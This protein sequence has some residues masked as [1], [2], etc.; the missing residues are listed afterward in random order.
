MLTNSNSV[1]SN[2]N[3]KWFATVWAIIIIAPLVYFPG[4]SV[5]TG[6]PW[7]V[8]LIISFVLFTTL[9]FCFFTQQKN[10][11]IALISPK[12]T[13]YIIIP[14]CALIIWSAISAFWADSILS[15]AHHSLVWVYYLIFFLLSI[16]IVSDKRL[17]KLST[18][19]LGSV[20]TIICLCCVI[21]FIQF[22]SQESIGETFGTRFGR[23]A[24]IFA[25]LLPLF[26]SFILRLNRKH[27]L[28]AVCVTSFLWLGL[29][30]AGSRG[31]LFSSIIG[32]S[33][34][35][36]LRIF[37]KKTSIEKR[38]LVLALMG[39]VFTV[40]FV[41]VSLL[42]IQNEKKGSTISRF[43]I[44]DEKE[45][46]NSF[47]QNIRFLYAGVGKEMFFENYLIGVGADNFGLEFNK[48]RAVFSENVTNK[49]TAQQNEDFQAERAH[50]E[51]LQILAELGII[52]G[53]IFLCLLFGIAKLGFAEIV[54]SRFERSNILTHAAIGG[55]VAFLLSSCFSSFSFRL[56]QNGLVFF[57]L[58]AILLRNFVVEK[59]Q[60]KQNLTFN[61]QLKLIFVSIAL[62]AS[63]SLTVFSALKAT[64]Q[65][66]TYLA[67]RQQNFETAKTYYENA[68]MLDPAN[69]AAESSFGARLLGENNYQESAAHFQKSVEKGLNDSISYSY[70]I[71]AQT[72][73]NEPQQAL[74]TTSEAV[75]IFPYSVF[76]RVRYAALLDNFNEKAESAKQLKIARQ[77]DKKQS[78]TWWLLMKYGSLKASQE[79]RTNKDI[80]SLEKLTPNSGVY[81]VLAERQIIHPDE[82]PTF[83]F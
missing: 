45:S 46:G 57:F 48:Y 23:Y 5:L 82:K 64:S 79:S 17:F 62:V 24:E 49:Y 12:F 18:I 43:V 26:F 1:F 39:L 77:L 54:K 16:N 51:Y 76:M 58:L 74:D 78:E 42:S 80:S 71:T 31:S 83:K 10:K 3:L 15:V 34:F 81:A 50:N 40:L 8:E 7:K 52:G 21:G 22:I 36:L 67:E 19:A 4:S 2:K 75:K 9:V 14:F 29:L 63:L 37:S 66:L 35:V 60:E 38:R 65:Y 59:N 55:I 32:L 28:W 44:K 27:L 13:F 41:Q 53:I 70:L 56:M 47:S 68:I 30:F 6:H 72:L 11:F 69:A 33:F 20:M 61:P 73:A 25:T